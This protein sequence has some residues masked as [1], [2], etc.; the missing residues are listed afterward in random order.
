MIFKPHASGLH[1]LDV[2]DSRSHASYSFVKTVAKNMQMF[3]KR[4]IASALQARDLQAGLGFPSISD[5]KWIVK[6]NMLE[7]CPVVSQD[8]DVSIKV[9]GKSVPLLKGGTVC[10]KAPVVTEDVVE[11]PKE[12]RQLHKRVTLVIEI[13][14]VNGTPYFTTLS[15]RI[16]FL[17]VTHLSSRKIPFIFKA[18]KNMHNFYLQRGFQVV[19]IKGDG[20]F[21]PLEDLVQ[22][23][24]YGG[25]KLNLASANE[26]V[27][28]IERKIRVIKEQTRAVRYSLHCNALPALV[29]THAVLF[30]TKQLNLFPVR[31]VFWVGARNKL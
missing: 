17:S 24:L 14:F 12:I 23:E 2:H 4:R 26:H 7:D 8:V 13:F 6:A 25:P 9:W 16:C 21:K 5:F 11:V 22:L 31:V 28:E 18:L 3:T 19:F 27:P 15:L 20:E 30:V 1:V 10:R 29:T